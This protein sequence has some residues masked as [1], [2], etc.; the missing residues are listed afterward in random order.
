MKLVHVLID[1]NL[2]TQIEKLQIYGLNCDEVLKE[3]ILV[4]VESNLKAAESIFL[5]K[6]GL[7]KS[8]TSEEIKQNCI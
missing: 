7:K 8:E 3:S 4:G 1:D 2:Y 5:S 6:Y